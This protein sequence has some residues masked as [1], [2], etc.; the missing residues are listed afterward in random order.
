MEAPG[1]ELHNPC[2]AGTHDCDTTAQCIPLEDLAF[3]CQC[4]TGYTGD[5]HNCYGIYLCLCRSFC[6]QAC[7]VNSS[8]DILC[9]NEMVYVHF[10]VLPLPLFSL[11]FSVAYKMSK[12]KTVFL[13]FIN[14]C[15]ASVEGSSTGWLSRIVCNHS[16]LFFSFLHPSSPFVSS[17]LIFKLKGPSGL[18]A[19]VWSVISPAAG[20]FRCWQQRK[21]QAH[22][23]F[24]WMGLSAP[25]CSD[26]LHVVL[27]NAFYIH[28][29]KKNV[30][31]TRHHFSV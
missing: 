20:L 14:I 13:C 2:Y 1:P 18:Q 30:H 10:R 27:H 17:R 23:K 16:F 4:A 28:V 21:P 5:G 19:G 24:S 22:P 29:R 7:R 15:P 26:D 11:A 3:Q 8:V 25:F 9:S 12:S 31:K 6:E